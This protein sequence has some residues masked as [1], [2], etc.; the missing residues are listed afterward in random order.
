MIKKFITA[1]I[2]YFV[3]ID[4][5]GTAS[6]LP[7]ITRHLSKQRKIRTALEGIFV[8]DAIMIFFALCGV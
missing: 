1:F 4:S 5:V 3:V 8:A 7:A 6:I 2:V